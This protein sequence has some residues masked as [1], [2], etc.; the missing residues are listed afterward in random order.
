[1][2]SRTILPRTLFVTVAACFA[3]TFSVI[4]AERD[5][6]YEE[7]ASPVSN[8]ISTEPKEK[9]FTPE[10]VAQCKLKA[11]AGNA[12][13]QANLGLALLKG[14]GVETNLVEAVNLLRK[15]AD[16][17]NAVGQKCLG[18]CYDYGEGVEEDD[19]KAVEC[20]RKAAEQGNADAQYHLG[21]HYAY[22]EGVEEDDVKA[23]EWY[24]KAA[25]QGDADAQYRLGLH[26]ADGE[27][28]EKDE[29]KAVEWYRKAAEM[30]ET[31][32]LVQIGKCYAKGK[33]VRKD[34]AKAVEWYRKAAEKGETMAFYHLGKCYAEGKGVAQDLES[35]FQWYKKAAE[36]GGKLDV[37]WLREFGVKLL[38]GIEMT[39]NFKLAA[40]C[41]QVGAEQDDEESTYR[42]GMCYEYGRGVE[43]NLKK[44]VE[45]YG[46]A[47]RKG[48]P[49]AQFS[50]GEAY[51]K[52]RGIEK[53]TASAM[54]WY[55]EA[56]KQGV[57]EALA[58][59]AYNSIHGESVRESP[60]KALEWLGKLSE[61]HNEIHKKY[62]Y[63]L[64]QADGSWPYSRRNLNGM[65]KALEL[66]GQK[67]PQGRQYAKIFQITAPHGALAYFGR[68]D[69]QSAYEKRPLVFLGS[70]DIRAL[71]AEGEEISFD[72]LYWA[73][74]YTYSTRNGETL[75]IPQYGERLSWALFVVGCN[76]GLYDTY[77]VSACFEEPDYTPPH[78]S[79]EEKENK[80][81]EMRRNDKNRTPSSFGSGFFI[82]TDGYFL[83]N[84]HVIENTGKVKI[85]VG[86]KLYAAEL[87]D[88][89]KNLDL[90]LL[91]VKEGN[92]PFLPFS[93]KRVAKLGEDVYAIGYPRPALQGASVKVTKGVISSLRGI[94]DDPHCY[95]IDAAIQPG[96]SGGPLIDAAGNVIGITVAKLKNTESMM[97]SGDIAQNVNYA[98]KSSFVLAF[99]DSTPECGYEMEKGPQKLFGGKSGFNENAAKACCLVISYK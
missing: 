10:F 94:M 77:G 78:E 12:E 48:Y 35:A 4:S 81:V 91:K 24:R 45:C 28:V 32:A 60:G 41:F 83:T 95:Q 76:L 22:G 96:N 61:I 3:L 97:K 1:M 21:F 62:G 13:A 69:Y 30:G 84:F 80:N 46:K 47:A 5:W 90:A 14:W 29:A 15:A 7:D 79:S 20:Y 59:L 71:H 72:R 26:Y 86:E 16:A 98:I 88:A 65:I 73:S 58:R 66:I 56:A 23:V 57:P 53:D 2:P 52:G 8:S 75:T 85:L 36:S 9:D 6:L 51:R 38:L 39:Q 34:D 50:L 19:A 18:E 93:N 43:E 87:V 89:D 37:F 33:G 64:L 17:G 27:G 11:Q 42:L 74:T 63:S 68:K 70:P 99:L 82:T 40:K 44:A 92:L 67:S 31:R 49:G 55:A 25:E 54:I